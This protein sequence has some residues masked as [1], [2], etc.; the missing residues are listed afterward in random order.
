MSNNKNTTPFSGTSKKGSV[1]LI[2]VL[3]ISAILL[4]LVLGISETQI[5]TSYQYVNS[6]SGKYSYYM[7]EACLEEAMIKLESN[8][9]YSGED[10][11][12][13]S[14]NAT[15]EIDV[16]GSPTLTITI[17]TTSGNYTQSF[18]AQASI[19]TNGQAN[20]IRLLNW[21]EI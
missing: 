20:N 3:I 18:Q 21:S 16:S 4:I 2:S 1:A 17:T 19:T 6:S 15:C 8:L 5:S 12:L 9:G 10:L 7:A 14:G 13:D 11:T